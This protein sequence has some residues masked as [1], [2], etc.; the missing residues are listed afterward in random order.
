MPELPTMAEAGLRGYEATAWFALLAPAKTLGAVITRLNSEVVGILQL[1]DVKERL[2]AQGADTSLGTPAELDGHIRS[3]L[4][5]W[6]KVI[7]ES[8][9]RAE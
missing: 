2:A 6:A 1:P 3:E 5:K 9:A 4:T 7:R 8:G